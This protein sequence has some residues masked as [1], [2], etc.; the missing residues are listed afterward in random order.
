MTYFSLTCVCGLALVCSLIS[1]LCSLP[2]EIGLLPKVVICRLNDWEVRGRT[3]H[4][5]SLF[6]VKEE[7][8]ELN[9]NALDDFPTSG[10]PI[11]TRA[12][13]C[14]G[15]SLRQLLEQ[16]LPN[17]FDQMGRFVSVLVE[18]HFL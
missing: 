9:L 17:R 3:I 12:A 7:G 11:L 6:F 5:S 16:L 14:P 4:D 10:V 8:S 13:L 1:L 2:K 18:F 15:G